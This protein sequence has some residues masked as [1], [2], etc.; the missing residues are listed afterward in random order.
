MLSI[1][2]LCYAVSCVLVTATSA[3]ACI[4]PVSNY[5]HFRFSEA[6]VQEIFDHDFELVSVNP[7]VEAWSPNVSIESF[8]VVGESSSD[9]FVTS[10]HDPTEPNYNWVTVQNSDGTYELIVSDCLEILHTPLSNNGID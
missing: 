9:M 7:L 5:N 4:I 1:Q 8:E 2:K 10:M 6:A 3:K